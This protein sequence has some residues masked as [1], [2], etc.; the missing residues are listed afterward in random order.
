MRKYLYLF[1]IFLVASCSGDK[2]TPE[3]QEI[4]K[5]LRSDPWQALEKL[6]N[7]SF[8]DSDKKSERELWNLYYVLGQYNSYSKEISVERLDEACEY[9]LKHGS[10]HRKAQ[11][12]YVRASVYDDLGYGEAT[13]LDDYARGCREVEKCNDDNLATLLYQHYGAI[14]N[15]RKWYE[16]GVEALKKSCE[17]AQKA[18]MSSSYVMSTINISHSYLF[19]GDENNDY[20]MAIEYAQKACD[21]AKKFNSKDSYSRALSAL[22]SCY[23]R[24][25]E[26]EKALDA[27]RESVHIQEE[28]YRSGVRKE[29]VRYSALADAFRKVENADS[30]IFYALKDLEHPSLVTRANASQIIYLAYKDILHDD[31][32]TLKYMEIN[33]EFLKEQEKLAEDAKVSSN[34]VELEKEVQQQKQSNILLT[35]LVAAFVIAIA[36]ILVVRLYKFRVRRGME[37]LKKEKET[38][39]QK[40]LEAQQKTI[41]AE[42]AL[43]EAKQ[44]SEEAARVTAVL[45]DTDDQ[46][47]ALRQ[48]PHYL[49]DAEWSRLEK[50]IDKVYDGW[51]SSLRSAG[52]TSGGM[53]AAIM[54]KLRFSNADAS[55]MLGISPSSFV[56]AKQRLKGKLPE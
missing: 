30:C 39:E 40:S 55:T 2:L 14:L 7:S 48:N 35:V 24:S 23:S 31:A 16:Q 29:L 47:E 50:T 38:A 6:D 22:A 17:Y 12:Y 11:S 49:S 27:S 44:A 52:V 45:V 51:C 34:Q 33:H 18:S 21:A 13:I 32:N 46:I 1:L 25:G 37:A 15:H 4:E 10:H 8:K 43:Q 9:F 20:S 42:R 36:F 3:F 28:M 19:L 56:K 5:L 26:F 53:R 54:V 41:E